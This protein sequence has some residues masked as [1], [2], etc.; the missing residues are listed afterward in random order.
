MSE[1]TAPRIPSGRDAFR[2]LNGQ[3]A[4]MKLRPNRTHRPHAAAARMRLTERAML[5]QDVQAAISDAVDRHNSSLERE[6]PDF[7]IVPACS[8]SRFMAELAQL[9]F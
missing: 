6:M 4:D 3:L 7:S 5:E 1:R 2:L 9:T 8:Q